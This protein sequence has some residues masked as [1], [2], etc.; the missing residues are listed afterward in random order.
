M[1]SSKSN[2][3]ISDIATTQKYY[4]QVDEDHEAKAARVIQELLDTGLT[5]TP[6]NKEISTAPQNAYH[7][8]P[9]QHKDLCNR[10]DRIRTYGLLLPKQ[11]L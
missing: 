1:K 10:G 11:A 2:T 5:L 9:L 7:H 4:N 3:K 8:K 6:E